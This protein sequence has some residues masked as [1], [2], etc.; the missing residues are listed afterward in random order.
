M[1]YNL[2]LLEYLVLEHLY[3]DGYNYL[4][5]DLDN[6]LRAYEECPGF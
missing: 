3:V 5:R 4:V 1:K 6:G 2:S